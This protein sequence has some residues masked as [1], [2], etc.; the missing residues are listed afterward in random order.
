MVVVQKSLR[1]DAA[2]NEREHERGIFGNNR[3]DLKLEETSA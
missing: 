1:T 2:S 3:G